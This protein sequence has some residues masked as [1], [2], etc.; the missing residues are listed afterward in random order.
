MCKDKGLVNRTIAQIKSKA[1]H[2][3]I[4]YN[5]KVGAIA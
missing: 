5:E 3:G 4:M 1:A 2:L